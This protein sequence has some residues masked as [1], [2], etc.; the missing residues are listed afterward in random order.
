[1]VNRSETEHKLIS[2]QIILKY[3]FMQSLSKIH[4]LKSKKIPVQAGI[5]KNLQACVSSLK[6]SLTGMHGDAWRTSAMLQTLQGH[7]SRAKQ[8]QVQTGIIFMNRVII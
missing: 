2:Y 5:Q 1:L 4:F 6:R 7:L 3:H 8:I